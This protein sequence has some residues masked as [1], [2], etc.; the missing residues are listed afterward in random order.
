MRPSSVRLCARSGQHFD[1]P[2]SDRPAAPNMIQRPQDHADNVA[3]GVSAF[4]KRET[5]SVQAGSDISPAIDPLLAEGFASEDR[6]LRRRWGRTVR[7][8]STSPASAWLSLQPK[9]RP[10]SRISGRD[11]PYGRRSRP[12]LVHMPSTSVRHASS[13]PHAQI[14]AGVEGFDCSRLWVSLDADWIRRII[15][16]S[17]RECEN[18][19]Y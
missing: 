3:L 14:R 5:T 8:P 17:T 7:R 15:A 10:S 19:A 2:E 11:G 12:A 4:L 6:P 16:R 18:H 13:F 1:L 9:H